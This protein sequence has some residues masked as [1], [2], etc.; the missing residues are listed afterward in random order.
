MIMCRTKLDYEVSD[1]F[2]FWPAEHKGDKKNY[3][4]V[5]EQIVADVGCVLTLGFAA[6][7]PCDWV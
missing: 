1:F 5:W 2:A 7:G 6:E 3:G 4:S